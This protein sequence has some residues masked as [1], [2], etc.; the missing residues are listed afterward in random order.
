MQAMV[1][2]PT[3]ASKKLLWADVRDIRRPANAAVRGVRFLTC[4]ELQLGAVFILEGL[5]L[6]RG[7]P[8]PVPR[9]FV[10]GAFV[11]ALS[12]CSA[13]ALQDPR[14]FVYVSA[15]EYQ[16]PP[17]MARIVEVH[18][19]TVAGPLIVKLDSGESMIIDADAGPL[20]A[21]PLRRLFPPS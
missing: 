5:K 9:R 1:S 19:A 21:G 2:R 15:K 10:A 7:H 4:V 8:L 13:W 3:D 18:G 16:L 11:H 17:L 6:E 20:P 14:L 12:Q